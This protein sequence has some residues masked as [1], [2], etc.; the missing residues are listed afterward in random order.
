M[1]AND[2]TPDVWYGLITRNG[3]ELMLT[4]HRL[5]YDDHGAT[6]ATVAAGHADGYARALTSGLWPSLD[7]LPDDER[8]ATGRALPELS[9]QLSK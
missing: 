5:V 2:G 1:P 9:M 4:T 7:V 3:G 6:A 8:A